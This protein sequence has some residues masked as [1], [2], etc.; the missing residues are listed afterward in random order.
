MTSWFRLTLCL[1]LLCLLLHLTQPP[2][3]HHQLQ[4]VGS[5]SWFNRGREPAP[6]ALTVS[7]VRSMECPA[8]AGPRQSLFLECTLTAGNTGP[9]GW[10]THGPS[11]PIAALASCR[12]SQQLNQTCEHPSARKYW[13]KPPILKLRRFATAFS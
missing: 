12:S 6:D 1:A 9:P 4:I 13:L 11:A 3:L 2:D 7:V 8:R 5:A 10:E